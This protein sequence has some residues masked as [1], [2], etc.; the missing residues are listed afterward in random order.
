MNLQHI[1][2]SYNRKARLKRMGV[3]CPSC[4]SRQV[5]L[6]QY[7][8]LPVAKW[9][10]SLCAHTFHYEEEW[11]DPFKAA[12]RRDIKTFDGKTIG[13]AIHMGEK[14]APLQSKLEGRAP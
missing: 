4:N 13:T 11:D 6:K 3:R 5:T 7:M 14:A 2:E 10:C 9:R 1:I 8:N 12:D